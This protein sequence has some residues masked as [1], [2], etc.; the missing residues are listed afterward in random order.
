MAT[1]H[2][3]TA[4][5]LA[6]I[7]K[8][9]ISNGDIGYIWHA[10]FS[11]KMVYDSTATN[12]T[13]TT[14]H[15]YYIRPNDF[16]ATGVWIEHVGADQPEAWSASQIVTGQL[17]STNCTTATGSEYNLDNATIK[18]GGT[19]VDAAGSYRGIFVGLDSGLYK[20]CA[21]D[22]ANKYFKFDGTNI[23]W[24]GAN[25]SLST[26]GVF[27]ATNAVLTGAIT[28]NSGAVGSFTIGTYLY[29][30]S[31]TAYND[32][33]AG[34]HLGS[35]GIGIG[36]NIFTVS[37]AGAVVATSGIVAGF[38]INATDGLYAGAAATRVQV[39]PGAAGVGGIW[40]GA[41][42][43]AD[44]KN[45]LDVDGSGKLANG[46][47]VWTAAGA[48]TFDAPANVG[49]GIGII[50]KDAKR[51]LYDFNPAHNGTVQP[52]GYNLFLGVEA[53]NLTIG[54][55]ATATDESSYN[56]GVGY[57]CLKTLTTGSFNVALGYNS[58]LLLNSGKHNVSIGTSALSSST[59]GEKNVAVGAL[60]MFGNTQGGS[61][62][63]IGYYALYNNTTGLRNVA[64]GEQAGMWQ[65]DGTSS[66]QTP[67]NSVYLGAEAKSGSDPAGG[68][69]AI[70]NEI[71]IGYVTT[72]NGSN[73][74]TLG[75]TSI[76][77]FHCQVA[78]T[79]DSD[80][81][82]KRNIHPSL[83][84]LD[85]I[86]ALRPI[87]FQP[88][89]P[90]DYPDKI[91]PPEYKDRTVIEKDKDGKEKEK[92]IKADKRPPD[93]DRIYLGLSA[94]EVEQVMAV[95]GVNSQIVVTSNRGKKAITYGN[96]IMPLITAVQ[97]LSQ[98]V[99]QL[100]VQPK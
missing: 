82:I 32:A 97:E 84:G 17:R 26:S 53:G 86:N 83:A 13:D 49:T 27:T 63:A 25:A 12:A 18:L 36:N 55:T 50:Y 81:R 33:N 6:T 91:K 51:W 31:K 23:S 66:L 85:F 80:E 61:N 43:V 4:T 3:G 92:V 8:A 71:V 20:L 5:T 44:A 37:A 94:Q 70:T 74:V 34:V 30:G 77:N 96:L 48:V 99:G 45:Y 7:P 22:G 95:Q 64:L 16:A 9:N 58:L 67:E 24:R 42:A 56:T 76:T 87:T 75:N 54:S 90:F 10:S 38:T 14:N 79:V 39:K 68:E 35:D 65:N 19:Q 93:N 11:R 89:N 41:T 28:A 52:N 21:G 98:K 88:K 47:I 73:T 2:F 57:Q 78:L 59:S 40:T 60:S 69:D 15:P 29:T 100:E 1:I 62:S 72:G 46:K